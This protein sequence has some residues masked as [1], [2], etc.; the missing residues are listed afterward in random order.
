MHPYVLAITPRMC[1][2]S[3]FAPFNRFSR[4]I[5]FYFSRV[6]HYLCGKKF[7][8]SVVKK[9]IFIELLLAPCRLLRISGG[10]LQVVYFMHIHSHDYYTFIRNP[11]LK[12]IVEY[13]IIKPRVKTITMYLYSFRTNFS[14]SNVRLRFTIFPYEHNYYKI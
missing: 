9:R 6:I 4:R 3:I 7:R 14:R 11:T 10:N 13:L 8:R 2:T 5:D 1:C 12:N